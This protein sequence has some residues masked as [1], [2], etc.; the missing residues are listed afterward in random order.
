MKLCLKILV[1]AITAV[2]TYPLTSC[3]GPAGFSYQNVTINFNTVPIQC[4][5][6][7]GGIYFNPANPAALYMP[8]G[9]NGKEGGSVLITATVTNAPVNITWT[10]FPQPNLGSIDSPPTG[11]SLPVGESD[12]AVGTVY[13]S[14]GTT[15]LLNSPSSV[16]VYTGA[17]L[18]QAQSFQWTYNGVQ[19]VGIPQGDVLLQASVP[20]D[21]NN[22]SAVAVAYQLEQVFSGTSLYLVPAMPATPTGITAP[23]VNVARGTSFA[24]YGG[25]VGAVPCTTPAGCLIAGTQYPIDTTDNTPVWS[26]GPAPFSTATQVVGGNATLGTITQNGVYTAPTTI[27]SPLPVVWMTSQQLPTITAASGS[28][29]SYAYV[30]IY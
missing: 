17:A 22:P 2:A 5:D 15:A 21:P 30:G 12:S 18:Q 26:V 1:V 11:T 9:G 20:S 24:F 25:A 14:S 6:C 7:P 16:P 4:S 3:A 29:L 13:A 23:I 27:P 8:A 19:R 10:I 28:H